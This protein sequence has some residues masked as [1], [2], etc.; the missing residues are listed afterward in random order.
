MDS[1]TSACGCTGRLGCGSTSR[2]SSTSC[3]SPPTSTTCAAQPPPPPRPPRAAPPSQRVVASACRPA[4]TPTVSA[5]PPATQTKGTCPNPQSREAQGRMAA[6]SAGLGASRD[7]DRP[8]EIFLRLPSHGVAE[9]RQGRGCAPLTRSPPPS[10]L[11][12]RRRRRCSASS[13]RTAACHRPST[14]SC[15]QLARPVAL[16]H[17]SARLILFLSERVLVVICF[18]RM[19]LVRLWG[20]ATCPPPPRAAPAARLSASGRP[21]TPALA[22]GVPGPRSRDNV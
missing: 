22:R 4:G 3:P 7:V 13:A 10:P 1:T 21:G 16:F 12:R 5:M 15:A 19:R 11:L 6:T 14:G 17:P 8:V 20:A 2:T 18:A 9:G